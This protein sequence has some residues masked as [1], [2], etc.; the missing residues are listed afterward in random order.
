MTLVATFHATLPP[1]P[2]ATEVKAGCAAKLAAIFWILEGRND[3]RLPPLRPAA[4]V[5]LPRIL[6]VTP[7]KP[8]ANVR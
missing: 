8:A 6:E 4:V 2:L 3:V 7:V 1:I 5:A